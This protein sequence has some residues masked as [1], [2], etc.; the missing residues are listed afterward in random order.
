[1]KTGKVIG[2]MVVVFVIIAITAYFISQSNKKK[3]AAAIATA[4][5]AN[6]A[7]TG[8]VV[9]NVSS[10]SIVGK[11]IQVPN[12]STGACPVGSTSGKDLGEG[13]IGENNGNPIYRCYRSTSQS[14]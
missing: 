14:S 1:M 12:L 3:T 7:V 4:P 11:W 9:A 13:P 6:P 5:N 10:G 2:I 8:R